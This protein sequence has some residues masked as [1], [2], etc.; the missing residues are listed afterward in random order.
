[1]TIDK[2]DKARLEGWRGGGGGGGGGRVEKYG[3]GT[4]ISRGTLGTKA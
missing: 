3:G 1:M 4:E 2:R